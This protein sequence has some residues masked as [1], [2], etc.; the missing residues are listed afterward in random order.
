MLVAFSCRLT[1]H[2]TSTEPWQAFLYKAK[3]RSLEVTLG[4][5]VFLTL[6]SELDIVLTET[7]LYFPDNI[8]TALLG[9]TP[10]T[11]QRGPLSTPYPN[12]WP[13]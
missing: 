2:R 8:A 3:T 13:L 7:S 10:H 1:G 12:F 5:V 9:S 4:V 6:K 11:V